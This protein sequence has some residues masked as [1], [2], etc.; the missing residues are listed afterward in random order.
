MEY[1]KSKA[2]IIFTPALGITLPPKK[3]AHTLDNNLC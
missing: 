1:I 2:L 3:H